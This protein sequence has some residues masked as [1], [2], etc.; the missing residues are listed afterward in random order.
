MLKNYFKVTSRNLLKNKFST[1]L[2]ILGLAI[3][4]TCY[5]LIFQYVN[6]QLSYDGYHRNKNDIY[7]LQQ[8]VYKNDVLENSYALTSFNAGPV[9]KEEYP[10]VKETARCIRFQN[11]TVSYMEKKYKNEKIVITEPTFF[12][13]FSSRILQGDPAT[14]LKGPKKIMLSQSTAE[15]YFS[16]ENP[17]GKII[18]ITTKRSEFSCMV[19]GIF[20]DIPA[21]SHLKFDMLLSLNTLY[22]DSYSDW[23]FSTV[24]TYLLLTPEAKANQL[25]S[26]LP[27]FID[28]YIAKEVPRAAN[29]KYRLQP[30]GEIYLYSD[31]TYDTENG[32]GKIVYFLLIIALIILIISWINYIN[33]S[34]AHA[35]ERA[36]EVG[37]R[38]VLGSHRIQLIK[39]FL[40]EALLVNLIPILIAVL[41]AIILLPKL[42]ELTGQ[43][44]PPFLKG[45]IFWLHLIGLYIIGSFLSG[46]YPAFVLSSFPPVAVLSR[47]KFSQTGSSNLLKKILVIFQY[48]VSTILIIFTFTVY[49]QIQFMKNKDL[50]INIKNLVAVTIPAIPTNQETK[51][52]FDTFKTELFRYPAITHVTGSLI[53]PGSP[54]QFQR[55]IWKE[56]TPYKDGK[57]ISIIFTDYDF[58]PTYQI[59]LA[60][61]RNFSQ[62]YGTDDNSIILNET[63]LELLGYENP[64]KAI[65][66]VVNIWQIP[67]NYKIIGVIKDYHQQSLKKSHAPIALLL[68]PSFKNYYTIKINPQNT[69]TPEILKIIR[70]Q[71]HETFP[72]NPLDYFFLE[73][74][75]N[76]QYKADTQ[77]GKVLGIFVILA[78]IITCLGLLG[79]T[80]FNTYQRRKEIAI[81]KSIGAGTKEIL[82]LLSSNIV[83]LVTLAVVIAWPIAYLII[84]QFLK[85]YAN[86]IAVPLL[87]FLSS[88]IILI[89]ITLFTS[90][91]HTISA[92][93]ANPVEAL[94]QE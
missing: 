48:T 32:D 10:E 3:G 13:V 68:N 82:L 34:T 64:Q 23:I 17:V 6:F 43:E 46:L 72:G 90:A 44:I 25:E 56:K 16:G 59:N 7:R 1:S 50:G 74:Y 76:R 33:L 70:S 9:L 60:A 51:Q 78:L 8:D 12:K 55:L 36:R 53:I 84:H 49:Q 45:G 42:R 38:K 88:G 40:S 93:R 35:M 63:A 71:W 26:K 11:N 62:K 5:L 94:K 57:I 61:G 20:A 58:I 80:Y 39:Q 69:S 2:N 21:N 24:Y 29:W 65:N 75:F 79:L 27:A 86:R 14:S 18:D 28:K 81:R 89:V 47:S 52:N 67:G 41:F 77:F 87:L 85:S 54:P 83:K 31:L 66:Q 37:L 4:M 92:A 30:L 73:D 22:P 15:K 19:T 91:Y